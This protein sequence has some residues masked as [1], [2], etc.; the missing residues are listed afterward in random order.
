MTQLE[1]EL[2]FPSSFRPLSKEELPAKLSNA[3]LVQHGL[4]PRPSPFKSRK[5]SRL[6]LLAAQRFR[7]HIVPELTPNPRHYHGPNYGRRIL[8]GSTGYTSDNWSGKVY[9]TG[10]PYGE[11]W[12]TW[13][14]PLVQPAPGAGPGTYYS[15]IWLGFGG[16]TDT[17][18]LQAGTEQDVTVDAAGN[19][20]RN[21]YAWTEWFTN[22]AMQPEQT[23]PAQQFP[24]NPGDSVALFLRW[25]GGA[26]GLAAFMNL[27]SGIVASIPIT[28]PNDGTVMTGDSVEWIVER[29][30]QIIDG[31]TTPLPLA[32]YGIVNISSAE[33]K[34]GYD[35]A[36]GQINFAGA[37]NADPI[38]MN[39]GPGTS[40]ISQEQDESVVHCIFGADLNT[41]NFEV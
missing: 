15:S 3:E 25:I 33:V 11:A 37:D 35:S 24:I 32:D 2:K 6:W 30:S 1:R 5:A 18:L 27:D 7:S 39:T 41:S 8:P 14:V 12:A 16:F 13:T 38:S 20:T 31:A 40:I 28:K 21:C 19:I 4:P 9:T 23:V 10:G 17:P 29:P 36:T 22:V 26:S 34:T